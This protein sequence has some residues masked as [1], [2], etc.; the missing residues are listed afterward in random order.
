[1]VAMTSLKD[2]NNL[3]ILEVG[4]PRKIHWGV[5]KWAVDG[6]QVWACIPR[7]SLE[8]WDQT[9]RLGVYGYRYIHFLKKNARDMDPYPLALDQ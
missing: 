6:L 7:L 1:M 3:V 9:S 4:N 5:D 8:I 2:Q